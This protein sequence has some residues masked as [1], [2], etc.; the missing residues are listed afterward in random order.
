V[1]AHFPDNKKR[2][3]VHQWIVVGGIET[4]AKRHAM[5]LVPEFIEKLYRLK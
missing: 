3:S 5:F 4:E 2:L 1:N